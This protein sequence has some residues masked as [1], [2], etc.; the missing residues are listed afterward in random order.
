[1][2]YRWVIL[3]AAACLAGK[4]IADY[5]STRRA[6]ARRNT[7]GTG[8]V[9]SGKAPMPDAGPL[10]KDHYLDVNDG[11]FAGTTKEDLRHL[12]AKLAE[13]PP[14][15][16]VV[17][18]HGGNVPRDEGMRIAKNL[19]S[20]YRDAG[21]YPIFFVWNSGISESL[22]AAGANFPRACR[23]SLR[24]LFSWRACRNFFRAQPRGLPYRAWFM[25]L[26]IGNMLFRIVKRFV[27]G[28]SHGFRAT[29]AEEFLRA[30]FVAD[31]GRAVWYMMRY[32]IT[33]AFE[34]ED[35]CAWT[36]FLLE[37]KQLLIANPKLRII[38]VAHSGGSIYACHFI[39]HALNDG[40]ETTFDVIFLAA[41]VTVERFAQIIR[42]HG[43]SI[44]KF[45]SFALKDEWERIDPVAGERSPYRFVYPRSL[46]Y[47][48]SGVCEYNDK[49]DNDIGDVP[50][51]GMQRYWEGNSAY[52]HRD[53]GCV[54][55]F[56]KQ[57]KS[58]VWS[59]EDAELEGLASG[60]KNHIGFD[61][62]EPT[63]KSIAYIIKNDF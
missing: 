8:V 33:H 26:R 61:E 48:M 35:D 62:D 6:G 55:E 9:G 19:L 13:N 50:L 39:E 25:L 20:V 37:L 22:S 17:H 32:E 12:F 24:A 23:Q 18:F 43:K 5:A 51:V 40:L 46:L 27:M 42:D 58:A 29:I 1:M 47:F 38:L 15:K 3:F 16:L 63:K 2:P 4:V 57:E 60:T 41:A 31:F 28:R 49:D 53:I 10:S 30:F 45:R 21:A 44:R 34:K 52:R 56:L 11:K 7:G 54:R 59:V 14:D 36:A